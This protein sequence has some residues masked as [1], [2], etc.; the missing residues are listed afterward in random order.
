M[1]IGFGFDVHPL[2]KGKPLIIGGVTIPHKYGL[3]GHSDADVLLHAISDALL[4]AAGLGDLGKHFPDSDDKYKGI[5]SLSILKE[6]REKIG[7]AGLHIKNIDCTVA[8]EKPVI[9]DYIDEMKKNISQALKIRMDIINIKATTQE[10]L[11][12]VGREEGAAAYAVLLL[13]LGNV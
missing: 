10:G 3:M 8:L 7:K 5:S 9:R 11:G 6:V 2:I 13:E 4:G 12:L 1:K